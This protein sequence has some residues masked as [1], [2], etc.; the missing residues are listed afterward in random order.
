MLIAKKKA[1][2]VDYIRNGKKRTVGAKKEIILSA[3]PI[4]TPHLLMLSGVGPR[5]HLEKLKVIV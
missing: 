1:L 3:G 2:G 5:E 4:G